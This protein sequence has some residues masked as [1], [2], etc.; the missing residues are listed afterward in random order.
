MECDDGFV[1]P[2]CLPFF[3]MVNGRLES[4]TMSVAIA[5]VEGKIGKLGLALG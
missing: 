3:T 4:T 5:E 1:A 2:F